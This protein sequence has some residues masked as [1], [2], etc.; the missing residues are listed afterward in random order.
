ME[1]HTCLICMGSNTEKYRNLMQARKELKQMFP[2]ILFGEEKETSPLFISNP[3]LFLNQLGCFTTVLCAEKII[4]SLKEIEKNAGRELQDKK[5]EIIKLDIDL[6]AYDDK[7]L[8]SHE[9][10]RK[11]MAEGIKELQALLL[12]DSRYVRYTSLLNSFL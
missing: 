1:K 9:F 5:E 10:S 2:D 6:L 3:S 8:K 12:S 7:I 4:E 11:Y